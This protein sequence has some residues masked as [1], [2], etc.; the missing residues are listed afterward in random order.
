MV[1]QGKIKLPT[2]LVQ[3]NFSTAVRGDA[4]YKNRIVKKIILT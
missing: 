3:H 4:I 1:G 2:L